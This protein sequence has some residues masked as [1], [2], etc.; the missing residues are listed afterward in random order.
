MVS[1]EV[2]PIAQWAAEEAVTAGALQKVDELAWLI[3][4]LVCQGPPRARRL[5]VLE[6]GSDA[7]GTL[8][9]W[10]CLGADVVAISLPDGPFSTGRPIEAHGATVLPMDSHESA[11]LAAL[12]EVHP[13]P[14]DLVF[15]DGDHSLTGV[16]Q[17]FFVYGRR[18]HPQGLVALHDVTPHAPETG[19]QVAEAWA[20]LQ[21]AAPARVTF[22][23]C[24]VPPTD[25]GGLGVIRGPW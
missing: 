13:E 16:L 1:N 7:G 18:C 5:Q 25:W 10:E 2:V 15:I 11:T 14:F 3:D 24:I 8:A 21:A 4:L 9:A 22:E 23:E 19:C 12:L 20:L 6:V 17:D